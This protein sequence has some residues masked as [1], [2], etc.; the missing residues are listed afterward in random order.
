MHLNE[1]RV[2]DESF[3]ELVNATELYEIFYREPGDDFHYKFIR[4]E[5]GG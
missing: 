2:R 3:V 5:S 4:E 1:I